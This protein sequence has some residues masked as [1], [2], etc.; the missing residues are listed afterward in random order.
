MAENEPFLSAYY[1]H[2]ILS[3]PNILESLATVISFHLSS[4]NKFIEATELRRICIDI[5]KRHPNVVSDM[6]QDLN[7][8]VC[9]D[10]AVR[11]IVSVFLYFKGFQCIQAYRVSHALWIEDRKPLALMIQSLSSMVFSV[12]I[13]PAARLGPGLLIDH[14]HSVVIGETAVVGSNCTLFHEV[15]L[16]GTGKDHGDRHPKIGDNVLIGAGAKVFGNITV[17]NSAKVAGGSVVL[18]NV[19]EHTTVAGIPAKVIGKSE[20]NPASLMNSNFF[21]I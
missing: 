20:N 2:F 7:A 17:G 8:V 18:Q 14:A 15:T 12:D 4:V 19:P 11:D 13:H 3:Q 10:P 21:M 16:G 6:L 5:F 9:R 1:H